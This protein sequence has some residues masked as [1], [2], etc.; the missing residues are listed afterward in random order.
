[1]ALGAIISAGSGSGHAQGENGKLKNIQEWVC[2][3]TYST[4]FSHKGPG[5]PA[6]PPAPAISK[7]SIR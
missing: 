4:F 1:M 6:P 2:D 7:L 5:I 3:T